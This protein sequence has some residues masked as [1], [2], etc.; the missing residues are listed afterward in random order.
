[1]PALPVHSM[2]TREISRDNEIAI[3]NLFTAADV[4]G[5]LQE[6]GWGETALS[7]EQVAWCERAVFLLGPQVANRDGLADLLGLV[8][9]YDAARVMSDIDAHGV[10]SRYAA[11][12]VIRVLAR[13]VLDGGA[14]TPERFSEIVTAMKA[15]LDIRGRELFQPLRLALA[16]RS[17]EG[18][19]D[20][21]ILLLDAAHDAGFEV[22]TVRHRMVQFC[23]VLE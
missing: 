14:C 19:L 13:L 9:A 17:G 2:D 21:V 4:A 8:F 1:M 7:A 15:E 6:R 3:V 18:G 16:G 22:K 20:R 11:R 10:M 23:S 12:D 5:V